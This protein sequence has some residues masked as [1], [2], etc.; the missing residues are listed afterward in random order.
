MTGFC[1][2]VVHLDRDLKLLEDSPRIAAL[3][4]CGASNCSR[5]AS[6]LELVCEDDRG[7]V[8]SLF[9]DSFAAPV[10]HSL[11]LNV[12]LVDS[13]SNQVKV[14]M[15]HI[16][17]FDEQ[18]EPCHLLCLRESDDVTTASTVAPLQ[19]DTV[20]ATLVNFGDATE[21]AYV[22]FDAMTFD[23]LLASSDF[24]A[25]FAKCTGHAANLEEMSVHDL[26]TDVGEPSLSR[27][28]QLV[29]NSFYHNSSNN[30]DLGVFQFFGACKMQVRVELQHDPVLATLVGTLH[31]TPTNP[32]S[33]QLNVLNVDQHAS[34][35]ISD[36]FAD[37]DTAQDLKQRKLDGFFRSHSAPA[38]AAS[39]ASPLRSKS[40]PVL[41][42]ELREATSLRL[43]GTSRMD[44]RG[45]SKDEVIHIGDSDEEMQRRPDAKSKSWP[46]VLRISAGRVAAAAGLHRHA[47]PG[48]VFI[49]LLYQDLPDMLLADAADAGVEIVSPQAERARLLAK[50]GEA[51]ALEAV[52][53]EAFQAPKVEAAQAAREAIAKAVEANC[54]QTDAWLGG[55]EIF[56]HA[57]PAVLYARSERCCTHRGIIISKPRPIRAR[58]DADAIL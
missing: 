21:Q 10:T 37:V 16:P 7:R 33:C 20:S 15:M 56:V 12:R 27:R 34:A 29:V 48:E 53:R 26:S 57:S 52:L 31:V 54:W 13:D 46:R 6:F 5:G 22:V 17:F 45:R 19:R 2:C 42:Q 36:L 39:V 4:L 18:G 58:L 3:L 32:G 38:L 44:I 51:E 25:L 1:D 50:S 30:V 55:S 9:A 24:E 23:I 11:A 43:K 47:D 40:A 49:E 28:I 41:G 8:R 35:N 14:E